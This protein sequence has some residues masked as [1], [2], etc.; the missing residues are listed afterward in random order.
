VVVQY[1]LLEGG[2]AMWQ[3]LQ[4]VNHHPHIARHFWTVCRDSSVTVCTDFN[5]VS[6]EFFVSA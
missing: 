5:N 6:G 4:G 2:V 3:N 1:T